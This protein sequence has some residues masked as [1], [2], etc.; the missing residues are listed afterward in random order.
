MV[1]AVVDSVGTRAVMWGS[2][3]SS[4]EL[5]LSFFVVVVVV[6]VVVVTALSLDIFVATA[7]WSWSSRPLFGIAG[8]KRI[9]ANKESSKIIGSSK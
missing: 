4:L 8:A 7:E 3:T 5:P 1:V 6:V 2:K 9:N